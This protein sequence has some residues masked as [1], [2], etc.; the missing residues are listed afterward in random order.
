MPRV[1]KPLRAAIVTANNIFRTAVLEEFADR[2]KFLSP[3]SIS[4]SIAKSGFNLGRQDDISSK[5]PSLCNSQ[6]QR[7]N[8]AT[9]LQRQSQAERHRQNGPP[10]LAGS[11]KNQ[12][13]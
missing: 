13:T 2:S 8:S 5:V 3:I 9:I 7:F 12:R 6:A 11:R 1:V 10:A 4:I